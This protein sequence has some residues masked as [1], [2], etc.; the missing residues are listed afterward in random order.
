[1]VLQGSSYIRHSK[2]CGLGESPGPP[3]QKS[4]YQ[5]S[6]AKTRCDQRYP[7][8]SR[9]LSRKESCKYATNAFRKQSKEVRRGASRQD[10]LEHQ[11][12]PTASSHRTRSPPPESFSKRNDST[13][14]STSVSDTPDVQTIESISDQS[15]RAAEPISF[16]VSVPIPDDAS[17]I[18]D[19][20]LYPF[21][22]N[23]PADLTVPRH[24]E[25]F[26]CRCIRT[27]PKMMARR[28]QVPP[29][30]HPTQVTLGNIELPLKNCFTLAKMWEGS[31]EPG[32]DLIEQ[33]IKRE[34]ERLLNEVRYHHKS[35]SPKRDY[36][37][38]LI[39]YTKVSI[40]Q[41]TYPRC[42]LPGGSNLL[43]HPYVPY[44]AETLPGHLQPS[45]PRLTSR[46]GCSRNRHRPRAASRKYTFPS[47]QLGGLDPGQ[48]KAED[49]DI[50]ILS[51]MDVRQTQWPPRIPV[52][53]TPLH[54]RASW[55]SALGSKD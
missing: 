22:A 6:K 29:F 8:C 31:N 36:A 54:A 9:C 19:R 42:S 17:A 24:T 55:Q 46:H 10:Q 48:C 35:R 44:P 12:K 34:T 49:T 38:L 23:A 28:E 11:V 14:R 27:W 47:S 21:V 40:I 32:S 4:C 7:S 13:S 5:C 16:R 26:I 53:G 41:S 52:H 33:T 25:E 43:N 18:R 20:W 50:T 2:Q 3:R 1:M 37:H 39:D 15:T 45:N 30:I 51:R